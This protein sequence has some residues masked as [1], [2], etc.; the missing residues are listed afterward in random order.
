[1][2]RKNAGALLQ[3]RV[4]LQILGPAESCAVPISLWK[5]LRVEEGRGEVIVGLPAERWRTLTF[6]MCLGLS[7]VVLYGDMGGEHRVI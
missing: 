7:A 2:A 1:M 3:T 5:C 6:F 4:R